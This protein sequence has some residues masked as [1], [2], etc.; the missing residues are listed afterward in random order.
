MRRLSLVVA[1]VLALVA[2][3]V[4]SGVITQGLAEVEQARAEQRRLEARRTELR[5][6]IQGME[7][8]LHR[9][10]TDPAAVE[11]LARRDLGWIR[12]G[13]RIIYLATPTPVP[14]PGPLTAPMPTPILSSRQVARGGAVR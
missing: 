14:R 10:R 11:S 4:L 12:P 1:V 6:R 3:G 13:E 8:T 9:L 2:L 7:E 5:A